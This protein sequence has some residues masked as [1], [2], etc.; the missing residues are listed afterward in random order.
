MKYTSHSEFH[1]YFK[2]NKNFSVGIADV[3]EFYR[4]NLRVTLDEHEDVIL[5]N[6]IFDLLGG[7]G[8][9]F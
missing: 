4:S 1:L 5:L 6:K 3:P 2:N 7:I 9:E 8:R